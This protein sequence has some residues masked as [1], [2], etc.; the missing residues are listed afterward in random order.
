M[1]KQI[2]HNYSTWQLLKD[3]A[4][5]IKPYK[6]KFFIAFFLRFTSDIV[7]LFPAWALSEIVA[8]LANTNSSAPFDTI[9]ILLGLWLLAGIYHFIN[10]DLSKYWGFQVAENVSL[11][12]QMKTIRHMFKLDISWHEKENSGNKMKRINKGSMGL[13]RLLRIFFVNIIESC[14]NIVVISFIFAS[15]NL[16]MSLAL[17]FFMITYYLLSYFLTKKAKKQ[18]YRVHQEEEKLEGINFEAIN[19]IQSIKSLGMYRSIIQTIR[20]ITLITREEIRKRILLFRTREA[21]LNLYN[22]LF[23]ITGIAYL[24]F[25][26]YQGDYGISILVLFMG[27]FR[28][29]N[30]ATLEL[31]RVTHEI[32]LAK[33]GISRMM[34][35]LLEKPTIDGTGKSIPYPKHWKT[36]QLKN[37][38]F[39]YENKR[40]LKNLNLTINRGEKIGIVGLSGAGKTTLFKLLLDLYENFEGDILLDAISLRDI[41]RYDYIDHTAVVMQETELFNTSIKGNVMIAAVEDKPLPKAKFK[42]VLETA[43]LQDLVHKLPNGAESIVGEKGVKLSGGE[44]QRLGIARALYRH[45]DILLLDEATSHLDVNSEKKIQKSLEIFF[46]QVTAIVIAHR[47]STIKQMDRIIVL[48]HGTIIEQGSFEEL[49]QQKGRF[50]ELWEKQSNQ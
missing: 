11:D 31:S 48:E 8:F 1:N 50:A 49:I 17:L 24:A 4:H 18:S 15:I 19:N 38:S 29:I 40:T 37:V 28:K 43:Q 45:P 32:V 39:S 36:I 41:S 44:K 3:I 34:D 14:I 13:S 25:A 2:N 27:Y 33:I 42:E 46:K 16:Q 26:I 47:L 35:I 7:W 10:H 23:Q 6:G 9:M 22:T 21:A 20:G 12:A 5:F 30:T